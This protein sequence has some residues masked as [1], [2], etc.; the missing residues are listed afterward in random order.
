ML[1]GVKPRTRVNGSGR[2]RVLEDVLHLARYGH[3]EECRLQPEYRRSQRK[4]K[5]RTARKRRS[6][7][8]TVAPFPHH[9]L[10]CL[11]TMGSLSI[12]GAYRPELTG[13]GYE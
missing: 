2:K 11:D 4:T 5:G 10:T 3:R 1:A 8:S 12:D 7:E 9:P 13:T 6:P